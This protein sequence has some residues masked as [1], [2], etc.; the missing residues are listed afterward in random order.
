MK[1]I[2]DQSRSYFVPAIII[3]VLI[4]AMLGPRQLNLFYFWVSFSLLIGMT[5][6]RLR[7][8]SLYIHIIK[9]KAFLAY[10]AFILW[11]ILSTL[12]WSEVKVTS[13][14]TVFTFLVGLLSYFVAYT[15]DRQTTLNVHKLLLLLGGGLALFTCYQFFVLEMKRPI[16]LLLNWNTHAAILGMLILPWVLRFA[17]TRGMSNAQIYLLSSASFFSAFAMGLTQ[18]RGAVLILASGFV[19]L[20]IL[21]RRQKLAYKPGLFLL[22]SIILG[23]FLSSYFVSESLLQRISTIA[24]VQTYREASVGR[25]LLWPAAWHMYLDRPFLGW[26]LESFAA[27]FTQYKFP[28]HAEYGYYAHNDYLQFLLELGPIGLL[29]FLSFVFF[30]VKK[31]FL[32]LAIKEGQLETNKIAA[33]ALLATCLGMLV[34]TFFTFHLYQLSIQVILGYYLGGAAKYIHLAHKDKTESIA[35]GEG[36]HFK[37]FY[38]LAWIVMLIT[39]IITGVASYHINKA[40]KITDYQ[41]KMDHYLTAGLF[42]PVLEKHD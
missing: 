26:G 35:L 40:E 8:P 23:Y 28:L 39:V 25:H 1:K 21:I 4:F 7:F 18:S 16:G 13:T 20:F 29:L 42:F 38:R 19:L 24:E 31:L 27:L 3:C 5:L 11:G 9:D 33:F 30:I 6:W 34:H 10:A 36:I 14:I 37:R 32:V 15:D 2:I 22:V 41:L 17:L 12:Y